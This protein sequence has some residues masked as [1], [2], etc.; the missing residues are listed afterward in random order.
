MFYDWSK[1]NDNASLLFRTILLSTMRWLSLRL[2]KRKKYVDTLNAR[3]LWYRDDQYSL[4]SKSRIPANKTI[5][6]HYQCTVLHSVLGDWCTARRWYKWTLTNQL[7]WI[8][9]RQIEA[10]VQI[11]CSVQA[12]KSDFPSISFPASIIMSCTENNIIRGWQQH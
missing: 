2:K 7:K 5:M 6:K 3:S 9:H 8:E 12:R 11:G 4:R 1:S 10:G